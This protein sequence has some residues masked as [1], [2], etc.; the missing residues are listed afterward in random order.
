MGKLGVLVDVAR[1]FEEFSM[2]QKVAKKIREMANYISQHFSE[3]Q[4]LFL[5]ERT[6]SVRDVDFTRVK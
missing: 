4:N 6:N 3:F 1:R 5:I 2:K